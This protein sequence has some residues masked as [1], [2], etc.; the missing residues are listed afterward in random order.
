MFLGSRWHGGKPAR[1]G[2]L[3]PAR[4]DGTE[5]RTNNGARGA[6]VEAPYG[7]DGGREAV[8]FAEVLEHEVAYLR[9]VEGQAA[10]ADGRSADDALRYAQ[11]K[12]LVGLAL[13]G[14]G[15]RSA[16]FNL[17]LLQ[18]LADRRLLGLFDYLSTV[19]GGGYIG[20]WL[21]AWLHRASFKLE[22]NEPSVADDRPAIEFVEEALRV[23]QR[24]RATSAS[25]GRAVRHESEEIRYLRE[26]SNYLTPRKGLL[27][28][29][30]LSMVAAYLGSVGVNLLIL[31]LFFGGLVLAIHALVA[32]HEA[33]T[34]GWAVG[35][36]IGLALLAALV[37]D[38]NQSMRESVDTQ[39]TRLPARLQPQTVYLGVVTPL[40]LG[41][42]ALSAWSPPFGADL[43][44][45]AWFRQHWMW[46]LASAAAYGLIAGIGSYGYWK[47]SHPDGSTPRDIP[48]IAL[49]SFVSSFLALTILSA[50]ALGVPSWL[51]NDWRVIL[52]PPLV[53]FAVCCV[54]WLQTGLSGTSVSNNNREWISRLTGI[55]MRCAATWAILFLIAVWSPTALPHVAGKS[56]VAG[57]AALLTITGLK[58]AWHFAR[59]LS[60]VRVTRILIKLAPPVFI[61]GLLFVLS[62]ATSEFVSLAASWL[63]GHRAASL[64]ITA[65]ASCLLAALA[66]SRIGI[67]ELSLNTVYRN[68]LVRTYIGA[69]RRV[70][71]SPDDRACVKQSV[72]YPHP[73]TKFAAEEDRLR[74]TDLVYRRH[75]RIPTR[76]EALS[77]RDPDARLLEAFRELKPGPG[78]ERPYIIYNVALNLVKGKRLDWQDRKARAFMITPDYAGFDTALDPIPL[79]ESGRRHL[80]KNAYRPTL[81]YAGEITAGTAMS[82]SGA[83]VAPNMG[84]LSSPF[85]TF[86][87][88]VFN[89]RLGRWLPNPRCREGWRRATPKLGLFL[90][91]GELF[92]Q[93]SDESRYVYVSDGGHF[94][95]LGLY[96][97]VHRRCKFIVVSDVSE[98]P[99]PSFGAL[100][101]AIERIRTDFGVDIDICVDALKKDPAS[102]YSERHCAVGKINYDGG[103]DPGLLLYVKASL[104]GQEPPDVMGYAANHREFPHQSTRDQFFDEAQF[105]A[106][107]R[108][109]RVV[110]HEVFEG[111]QCDQSCDHLFRVLRQ[112]WGGRPRQDPAQSHHAE[113]LQAI[114]ERLQKDDRLDVLD[115]Q[116]YPEWWAVAKGAEARRPPRRRARPQSPEQVR[117]AFYVCNEM[118][119]LMENV[120]LDLDLDA[121]L[122]DVDY[123]GWKNLFS[124]WSR[125]DMFRLTWAICAGVH[126]TRFQGFCRRLNLDLGED[127]GELQIDRLPWPKA[128]RGRAA[129]SLD[130]AERNCLR[131][132]Q[133]AY[134]PEKMQLVQLVLRIPD[135]LGPRRWP[136][137]PIGVAL[138]SGPP[139]TPGSI[140]YLRIHPLLRGMGLGRRAIKQLVLR[141][142]V[143]RDENHAVAARPLEMAAPLECDTITPQEID[144][145]QRLCRS[146]I[147]SI[148]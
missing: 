68:R 22:P 134:L 122:D 50:V 15:I 36:S 108:L 49:A 16:T 144:R 1:A 73:F 90:M 137:I 40:V 128:L 38:L 103:E 4:T 131:S 43:S 51:N 112:R 130:A 117:A 77:H 116:L 82:L 30:L 80:A 101:N 14:G 147:R 120:Y 66:A 96:E 92:G 143:C 83:A 24:P 46:L 57:T 106:Y 118:I 26:Y 41:S 75:W 138:L 39:L 145:F 119:H 25:D 102:G 74:L 23:E 78:L 64:A 13:S 123:R 76:L 27:G 29:D 99:A 20:T 100:A 121:H 136:P 114:L 105:E 104:T 94:E 135:A 21:L 9:P 115:A 45:P 140:V 133:P 60:D 37:G 127:F 129:Q 62:W 71:A 72:S 142:F 88:G 12:D 3:V 58:S 17:G 34:P 59:G 53:M 70:P 84:A 126:S 95:N 87:L 52:G 107:R 141:N 42:W 11:S 69:I 79:D 139:G 55:L 56:L 110:A 109:G 8:S 98:D 5:A 33:L 18:G 35:L 65:T 125:T 89:L 148:H 97:L 63:P 146:V 31:S 124:Q 61:V 19:S 44:Y 28:A 10:E 93:T 6:P 48:N 7:E 132:L 86:L 91:L 111:C 2:Q 81:D 47:S 113:R 67:N 54:L 85:V 32:A